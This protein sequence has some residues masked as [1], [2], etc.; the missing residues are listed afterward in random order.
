MSEKKYTFE[1][2]V[3]KLLHLVIHSL[4]SN[5][6]IFLR[7]LVSNSSDAIEKL[8]Y[9]SISNAALNEDDTDYAIRIDFDKDAKTITVSDNGIGMTE[10]EV[11]ENLGTIAKSGT[12]KFLESLTGDKSKDNELI[13]QFGV[14]FYSSF[15]VADK[16][17]VRTRKAGQDKSQATKWVSDAQNG[18]TVETITKEKRGT[19]ITLHIKEDQLDLLDYHL[20]KSLVNKYSDCINTPIQ[21]KKVEH[22][23][24][25]KQIIKD[26][27][28]T[29]NNTKAIWLRSKDE[30]TDEEYQEFY[31]YISHDFADALMWIHNKVEGNLE[32]NSLL[33]IPQNK[34]FDF[35]NRDKDYGLSLYV[36][37]V[38]IMEN[39]E[40][41][42]PY[43]RFVKGVIDSADLPLNVSREIL[44]HNK[45]IDKI[46]KAITTKILSELK[47][48]ASK[49]TEK[50]QKFWD[51]FG[52]VLKEGVS[53]DYSN[54]E[55]IAGL[56]RFATTES[57]DAKQ[58]V[59]L[60]DYVSRMKEGQDTIY[61]ITSDS[62][63][64]AVNNP[65]LEAF[66]KKGIEVILM[67]D[68]I[69]EW[70]MSTL[71]EFDGKHMKSIIKGDI[72]LDKFETPENKEKF[73]KEAKDFE[74]VLKEIKEVLKDKV[75]DVR[76][77]KRLTDS[78]SCVV[79]NDY[80]MSL[81][82]QKMMEEA[83]QG[84]MPGMGM[85]PI[86][87]LNAEHNLVQKLKNEADTEIF[88]D[89]SELLLLQAMFVEGAKIED[90]M[91]FVKLVNKY[92]R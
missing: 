90:P 85:K 9:E 45:V 54:K 83:G 73:E 12:K 2:E 20:L 65:Q 44:Q 19:E 56:L 70:M 58:T 79:V 60:A 46:K 6:E 77:S 18:F 88:A 34:P 16:V 86:L 14:G 40:L 55:K 53:D 84:F 28:E 68:R 27:Y 82:M 30:V 74:K 76:L 37:R 42:P 61:Y 51:S 71:T 59:S 36:R 39:K 80:G 3:D 63:K 91:A 31:K 15:I 26:E 38:F 10:E 11:I 4:Y 8:R 67:T 48:L 78:P 21:M 81:H 64:A 89:L 25:G 47:K 49:D 13:G 72:D 87:E 75:E 22:D 62:Y 29:V 23:K 33:Y 92:I 43:L 1:T 69:D 5:R 50:Y 7:E 66:K 35:W 52:Q 17:T 41:L 32:Y 24:D 57:G